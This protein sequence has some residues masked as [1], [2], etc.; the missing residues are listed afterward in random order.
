MT[1]LQLIN[2]VLRRLRE[3]EVSA[4]DQSD[5]SKLIGSFI[6]ETKREV[7]DAWN[8]IQ[9]RSTIQVVMAGDSTTYRYALTGAGN[10]YRIL[11][12][13][14]DS[15]DWEL[16][17]TP[18]TVMNRWFTEQNPQ[19][20]SPT[21]YDINGNTDGDPNVDFY[22]IPNVA[23]TINFNLVLPQADL[24]SD[25][26]TLTVPSW[27]VILGAYAKALSER[28]EDGGRSYAEVYNDYNKA[29]SDAIAIDTMGVQDEINWEVV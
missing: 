18:Y 26:D 22:P 5:Y 19:I 24:S 28:G 15:Q 9:L 21:N 2:A 6:N 20:D 29:L 4:Y 3:T 25:T 7:E 17:R 23:D 14:N 11:Q 16:C 10:R 8:W 1:Y 12:V 27:P 13:I